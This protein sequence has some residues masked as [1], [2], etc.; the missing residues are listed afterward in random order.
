[1]QN[2]RQANA[3]RVSRAAE[4]INSFIGGFK[5]TSSWQLAKLFA[6]TN[7]GFYRNKVVNKAQRERF[8]RIYGIL[9][10]YK[11]NGVEFEH[12]LNAPMYD[13]LKNTI[14]YAMILGNNVDHSGANI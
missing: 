8:N 12:V 13:T 5:Y 3:E 4:L 7:Y 10:K 6:L 2:I 14:V 9:Y 1:M 11:I